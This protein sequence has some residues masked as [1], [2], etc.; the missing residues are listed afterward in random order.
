MCLAKS[1]HIVTVIISNVVGSTI[2]ERIA[3]LVTGM[4]VIVMTIILAHVSP[5]GSKQAIV[6]RDGDVSITPAPYE[7][8]IAVSVRT[9][10]LS[11]E[12]TVVEGD[13]ATLNSRDEATI[14]TTVNGIAID[15]G[16]NHTVR[17]G[18]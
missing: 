15:A 13:I 12:C 7:T 14:V 16:I 1:C 3:R 9:S 11:C 10:Q 6:E 8:A 4:P 18:Y 5:G 2:V 17:Y